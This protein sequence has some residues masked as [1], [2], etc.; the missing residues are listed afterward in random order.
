M[1]ELRPTLVKKGATLGA[2]CT[3]VCGHTIGR[4]AFLGAGAAVTKDVPDYALVVGVPARIVGW[5]C[6]CGEKLHFA[7][8]QTVCK[9]CSRRYRMINNEM[10]ESERE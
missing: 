6:E 10:V 4:Y 7:G 9:D 8:E 5:V 2:N 1:E 3:V